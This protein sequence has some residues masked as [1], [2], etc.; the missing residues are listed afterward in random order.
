MKNGL[1]PKSTQVCFD[2]LVKAA[3]LSDAVGSIRLGVTDLAVAFG[4]SR[5]TI[6][7][8]VENGILPK[9]FALPPGKRACWDYDEI[10]EFLAKHG[11]KRY[12]KK[13]KK[14]GVRKTWT[15]EIART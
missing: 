6:H 2:E 1:E 15:C 14:R 3:N 10:A 9:P 5:Y 11:N 4:T 13:Y 8:W 7:S 12:A